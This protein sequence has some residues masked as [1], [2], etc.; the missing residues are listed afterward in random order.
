MNTSNRY[1]VLAKLREQSR[2]LK[3]LYLTFMFT[4]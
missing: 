4:I 3:R 2:L 1:T